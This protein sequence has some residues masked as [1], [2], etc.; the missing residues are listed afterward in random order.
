MTEACQL[1]LIGPPDLQRLD[2]P[3]TDWLVLVAMVMLCTLAYRNHAPVG[4]LADNILELDRGVVDA[5]VVQQ[6][7]FYVAQNAFAD[8]GRNIVDRDVEGGRGGFRADAPDVEIVHVV[9]AFN[10]ANR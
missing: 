2:D 1:F 4:N 6:A 8:R 7:I 5:E 3:V 9:D 10:G